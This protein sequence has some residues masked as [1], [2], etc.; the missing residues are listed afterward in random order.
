MCITFRFVVLYQYFVCIFQL[1][2]NIGMQSRVH[3]LCA[4]F[5]LWV[6]HFQNL[7]F[8]VN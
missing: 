4:F 6:G 1:V 8:F 5:K 7:V 3:T 2:L